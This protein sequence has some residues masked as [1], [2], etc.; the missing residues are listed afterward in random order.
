MITCEE[1]ASLLSEKMDVSLSPT[2]R[3]LL[4]VHMMM[5]RSCAEF[6]QQMRSLRDIFLGLEGA[7]SQDQAGLPEES[8][9]RIKQAL[10][11]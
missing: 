6:G 10:L 3:I 11:Q 7:S 5:C 4:Q 9:K 8:R 2:Q 1:T